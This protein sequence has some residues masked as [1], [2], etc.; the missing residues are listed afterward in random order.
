MTDMLIQTQ[1]PHWDVT[2]FFPSLDSPQFAS[3]FDGL[4]EAIDAFAK[5]FDEAG[6]RA[7]SSPFVDGATATIFDELLTRSNEIAESMRL[8]RGY[9][10]SLITTDAHDDEAQARN[11]ELQLLGVELDKLG[12][13]YA[14]WV[15][16]LD[17][18]E[19]IARSSVAKAH[20]FGVRR[21]HENAAFLMSDAE[22]ALASSLGPSGVGAWAKLHGNVTSRVLAS[23]EFP[24]GRVETLPM[25]AVRGLAHDPDPD[26]RQAAYRA[27]MR[28]WP[29]VEV[30][31][32]AALNSIKGWHNVVNARRGYTD[33]LEPALRMNNVDRA[34]LD[35]MQQAVIEAL[36]DFRRYLRA[37][38][39]LLGKGVLA[40]WDLSAPLGAEGR[41]W[42]WDD[43]ATFVVGQFQTFSD[44][45]AGLAARAFLERW[46]D[47][48]PREGKRDGGFCMGVRG[49]ESRILVNF[50][51]DF[52]SVSTVAHELGH[53]YHNINLAHRTASQRSTPM[54]LAETASTF[55][56]TIVNNAMLDQAADD[57]RLGILEAGLAHM[58]MIT[59]EIHTRFIF[60]KALYERRAKR[61]LAPRE[62]C[63]LLTSA[64]SEVFG[65][66][67]DPDQ[68]HPYQWALKP[69]YYS[70]S[71]YNW[72]YTFGQLFG[73]GLYAEYEKDADAFRAGYDD[74]LSSTGMFDAAD[75]A[76]R[77]GMDVRS[78]DLWRSSLDVVRA[79]IAAFEKLAR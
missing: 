43:T 54:A 12:K 14:A 78:V 64:Q 31:L 1:L 33:S 32:A 75:L 29:T 24:D 5:R 2:S 26:V 65:D 63:E 18:D 58:F 46:I 41:V 10:H 39:R 11:S 27:E 61:E 17:V 56:E 47:A 21:T 22:E 38:A 53:A 51:N 3:A 66:A 25:A 50:T 67:V 4:A 74:L 70:S 45:L 42:D 16:S 52:S 55:C 23:V 15:G 30:P 37:K 6:I 76:A 19:L 68:L 72:P 8:V 36:P 9:V 28:T 49:D 62:L 48:E 35:A 69:H 34:T 13:R 44:R 73:T 20:E 71:Y 60:E 79:Q 7:A 40:W 77:F 57:E 59:A